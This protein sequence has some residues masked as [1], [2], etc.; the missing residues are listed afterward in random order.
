MKL[1]CVYDVIQPYVVGGVQKRNWEIA[2]RLVNK[3]HE[4]TLFGMKHWQGKD[5]ICREGVRLWGV[6]APLP[7]FVE[8]RRS[9][10]EA[11]Y[12]A[13]K[14][15]P[16]L[17]KDRY[18]VI[19]VANFPYFPCFSAWFCALVRRSHLVITWHEVWG[20]YWHQY[21]GKKGAFGKAVERLVARLPHR[22]IAISP[23]TG[24][25]LERLG[26]RYANIIPCGVDISGIA[27]VPR[28]PDTSSIIFVGRLAQ[29]K[30]VSQLLEAVSILR[31]TAS[32][33][34]CVII[35]EG[36]H[37][38]F[39]KRQSQE[40]GIADGVRFLGRVE[41]DAEVYSYIKASRVLVQ[42]STREGFSHVVLEANACGIPVVTVSHPQNA[43]QYL[44]K[45]GCNGLICDLSS[46]DMAQ[47]I[48]QALSVGDWDR[49]CRE[50]AA[51]YD[52]EMI[53]DAAEKAY[54][55]ALGTE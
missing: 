21:L 31:E 42:P 50:F 20:D 12:F 55:K 2:R 51:A 15:L 13:G 3:G 17:M 24:A 38:A 37:M 8:G 33:M 53:A 39:L 45:D 4:V 47:K 46:S 9:I 11:I 40:L 22:A 26:H 25:G 27:N 7:L 18:D 49:R 23:H 28:K 5:I 19:E 32:D 43:A 48:R 35:G 10:G 36:P 14:V 29:E 41:S 1:A 6:C 34:T 52:W 16:H 54:L 44:I 30:N